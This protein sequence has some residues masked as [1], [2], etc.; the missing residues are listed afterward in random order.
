MFRAMR[1]PEPVLH[2][3][4]EASASG[5]FLRLAPAGVAG[6]ALLE[7]ALPGGGWRGKNVVSMPAQK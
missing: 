1:C 6:Y 7:S 4:P 5:F 2:H 3:K